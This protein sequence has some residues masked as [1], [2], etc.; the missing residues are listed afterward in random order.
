MLLSHSWSELDV[1][2]ISLHL[3]IHLTENIRGD[4]QVEPSSQVISNNLTPQIPAIACSL[5]VL[6]QMFSREKH[7]HNQ[8]LA[9]IET[10]LQN[11]IQLSL[12]L[13]GGL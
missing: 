2:K 5:E 13:F 11:C 3:G 6:V 10:F 9:F 12:K 1:V 7:Q 4:Y 8:R